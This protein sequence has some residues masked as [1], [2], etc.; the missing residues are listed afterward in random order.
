VR[1]KVLE[2]GDRG[3][4]VV[5][6]SHGFPSLGYS[7]RRV[8]PAL[9]EAGYHVL[10][11]DQRGYGGSSRPGAIKAYDIAALTGDLVGLLDDAGAQRAVWVG[12]DLGEEPYHR[13]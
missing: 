2:A 9:A 7:W 6:L 13:P 8:V 11:S 12:H 5:L 3:A 4:P 10:A 1:L